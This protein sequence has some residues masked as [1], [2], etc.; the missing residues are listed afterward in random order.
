MEIKDKINMISK[1]RNL[2]DDLELALKSKNVFLLNQ[3]KDKVYNIMKS[4]G[5]SDVD[6]E[7][8]I[9]KQIYFILN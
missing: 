9:A 6:I 2:H 8:E 4:Y 5:V 3:Y 1:V 7:V